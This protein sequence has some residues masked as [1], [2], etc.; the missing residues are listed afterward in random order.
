MDPIPANPPPADNPEQRALDAAAKACGIETEYWDVFGKQHHASAQ[1]EKA[2]LKS[3]GV[4]GHG[5][6]SVHQAVKQ[7]L[8]RE[9]LHPLPP[10]T[11]LS[12]DQLPH[13]V[14]LSLPAWRAVP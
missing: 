13:E 7:R 2:I 4:N 9:W 1:V 3:L 14:V 8:E 10:T 11:V 12:I 5:G 6:R